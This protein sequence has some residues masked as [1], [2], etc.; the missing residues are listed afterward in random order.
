MIL[1]VKVSCR[2][3]S[4]FLAVAGFCVANR[5]KAIKASSR[6]TDK[7]SGRLFYDKLIY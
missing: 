5:L 2:V 3:H 4:H 7:L 6:I 1:R